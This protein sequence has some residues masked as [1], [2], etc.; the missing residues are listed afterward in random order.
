MMLGAEV[1][2][3]S[4]GLSIK[5]LGH[6][7]TSMWTIHT[8]L[9]LIPKFRVPKPLSSPVETLEANNNN[10]SNDPQNNQSSGNNKKVQF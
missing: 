7:N 8:S 1:G 4:W 10:T 9:N 6:V 5:E 2:L 3:Q